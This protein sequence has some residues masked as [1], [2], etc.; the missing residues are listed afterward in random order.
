MSN[1]PHELAEEFP[2]HVEKMHELKQSDAH[3]AKL[4]DAYHEVNRSV[5]RAETDVEPT[6]DF[7]MESMRK[8]R[9]K[10]KDE[11]YGMLAG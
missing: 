2:E 6:D 1:T 7:N 11:I 3:F 10:L 5:H 4:F 9:L 8:E